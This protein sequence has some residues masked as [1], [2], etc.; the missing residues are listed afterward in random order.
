MQV[1]SRWHDATTRVDRLF[2]PVPPVLLSLECCNNWCLL[3]GVKC[4]RREVNKIGEEIIIKTKEQQGTSYRLCCDQ[5]RKVHRYLKASPLTLLVPSVL[6]CYLFLVLASTCLVI[7]RDTACIFN[8][9]A[10]GCLLSTFFL[11]PNT[12][13]LK[14]AAFS[15]LLHTALCSY[16]R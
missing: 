15:S 9:F 2:R 3:T 5:E 4:C 11:V 6:A 8:F 7:A 10:L 1:G 14:S 12:E 16:Q 13:R